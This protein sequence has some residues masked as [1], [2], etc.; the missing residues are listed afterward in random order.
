M[1]PATSRFT[2]SLNDNIKTLDTEFDKLNDLV[3]EGENS[4]F[5][6]E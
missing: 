1:T 6:K 4:D 3:A 2:K 5:G